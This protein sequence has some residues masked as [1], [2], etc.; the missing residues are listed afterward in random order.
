MK[1]DML[2]YY[3]QVLATISMA[4]RRVFRKELRKAFKR[5]MPTERDQLKA[6][7]RSSC[8]CKVQHQADNEVRDL[9]P[10]PVRAQALK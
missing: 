7:F 3:Q 2:A 10:A 9:R 8:V 6:W 5:L 4:D 1:T